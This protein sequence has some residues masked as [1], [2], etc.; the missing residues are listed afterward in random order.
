MSD[1]GL[2]EIELSDTDLNLLDGN[3]D[4]F[5]VKIIWSPRRLEDILKTC[6]QDVFSVTLFCLPRCLE[7]VLKTSWKTRNCYAKD[8]LRRL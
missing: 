4:S 3:I 5:P 6:L 2:L 8:V 1:I 7:G